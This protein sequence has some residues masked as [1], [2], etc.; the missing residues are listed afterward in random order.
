MDAGNEALGALTLGHRDAGLPIAM[1]SITTSAIDTPARRGRF[2]A[3]ADRFRRKA[4]QWIA[5]TFRHLRRR[6]A[7]DVVGEG[8]P[9]GT[10]RRLRHLRLGMIG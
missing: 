5:A 9:G 1:S 3:T 7:A 2:G 10:R 4:R 6:R 8:R